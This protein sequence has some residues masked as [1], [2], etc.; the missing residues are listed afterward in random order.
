MGNNSLHI[1]PQN[2]LVDEDFTQVVLID[3]G[4]A[5]ELEQEATPASLPD[6][7]EGTLAYISPEQTGRTARNLDSRTDLYSLGVTFFEMLTGQ[8]PFVE[9]DA[10]AL[11]Y[12]H[13]AKTP[14]PLQSLMPNVPNVVAE[15]LAR[16]LEK[17]PEKR[18]QTAHGLGADLERCLRLLLAHDHIEAFA[19]GQQDYSPRLQIPQTLLSREQESLKLTA[20]FE[21][22]A[23]GAVEVLLLSGPS[24]IGKTALVHSVYRDIAKAGRGI[25]LS[26]KHDQ[27]GQSVP[28]AALAQAFSKLLSSLASSKRPMFE[29]WQQRLGQ[30]LGPLSRVIA[31]LVPQLEWLLGPLPAVPAVS[32]E[33]AYNRLKLSW[34]DFVRAVSDASPPLV[35]F[36]DD[37]Q[38]VD[39][40]SLELLKT[41][42]TDVGRKHLLV[43]AAY[44][45]NEVDGSHSLWKLIEAVEK[46]GVRTSR[47]T[48]GPLDESAVQMWLAAT[49]SAEPAR[50]KPLSIALF[51][52]TQGNPFFLGQLLIELHRQK[53]VRRNLSDGI[54]QWDQD[55]VEHAEVTANVVEL[56]RSKVVELPRPTQDLLGKAACA[57]HTFSI[58]ELAALSDLSTSQVV[59]A[60]RP[61]LLA[62]LVIPNEG[63]YRQAQ[64]LAKTEQTLILDAGYRFLHDRVQQ[65][66]YERIVQEER[67]RTHLQIGRQLYK[68]FEQQ[69]GSNQKLLE[70][71]RHLNLGVGAQENAAERLKLARLN[72]Q[73][74]KAAKANGSYQLQAALVEQSQALL[75]MDAWE[76]EPA[77]SIDLALERLE[78]D[79]ML[80]EFAEVHRRALELLTRPLPALP[81]LAVQELRLRT[82]MA[83]GQFGEGERLGLSALAEHGLFYPATNEACLAEALQGITICDAWLDANPEAFAAMAIDRS[84]EHLLCDAIQAAMLACAGYGSRPA[85][86]ILAI[87]RNTLCTI[88]KLAWTP[89]APFFVGALASA[90]AAFLGDYR[91][92][93]R[94]MKE[95]ARG[96][97]RLSSPTTAELCVYHGLYGV[98]ES[99]VEQTRAYCQK[100]LQFARASGSFA[101]TSTALYGELYFVELWGGRPLEQVA[102]MEAAQRELMARAGGA[103][104]RHFFA[105]AAA[106]AAFLRAPFESAFLTSAEWLHPSSRSFATLGHGMMAELGRIQ[107]A[108]LFL[109]FGEPQ[110]AR[111]RAEEAERFRASIYGR[112]PVTDIPLW[113]GLAAAKCCLPTLSQAERASLLSTLEHAIERFR[114]FSAACP[115]N[116]LHKL[117]LL[118][119]E[120]DR[121]CDRPIEAMEKYDAAI[122]LAHQ[123]RFLHIEGLAAQFCGEFHLSAGRERIAALYLH[124][125]CDAYRR[126]DAR[127]LVGFLNQKYSTLLRKNSF[128][129]F[130][131]ESPQTMTSTTSTT[132]DLSLDVNTTVRAAQALASELDSERIVAA[133]MRLVQENAGAQRAALL[134]CTQAQLFVSALLSDSQ[135][136]TG[137]AEPLSPIHPVA[138]SIVEYVLRSRTTLVLIDA[139]TDSQF[140]QDPHLRAE[141]IH[142]VLVIP[143]VHQGQL[144]GILYLEHQATNAFSQARVHLLGVLAAQSAIALETARLYADLQAANT[145][146]ERKVAERTAALDKA[147][148]ELWSEMDVAQKIQ[149]VL[150]P[151]EPQIA[152]YEIAAVMRPADQVGGDYYDVFRRGEQDWVLIGDVSGH[153]VPA[154]LCMMMIQAVLRAV[155]LSLER[156]ATPR[157]LLGLVNEAVADNLKQIGR[158]QYMTITALCIENGIIHYAGLHQELLVFRAASKQVERIETQGVWLGVIDGDISE[159][160]QDDVCA[161][162]PGDVLL[163]YTDGYP[164]AKHADEL[165]GMTYLTERFAQLAT[166]TP[167]CHALISELLAPLKQAEVRD[168]VTLIAL[169]RL[170]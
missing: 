125:A 162:E 17:A 151:S 39:P 99:P 161:L 78:A 76:Q 22:A 19:L 137:L 1:Q 142:S 28:Y 2:I 55:A 52:K 14:P 153:G 49:L 72:L 33:M 79:F 139:L 41:L 24:G 111:E 135:V 112:P 170:A 101:G 61:A 164:E 107:E 84:Q 145:G 96:A 117:R 65:A 115:E 5:S 165:L 30:A 54:W 98:Y 166:G 108:H 128:G 47:L 29:A 94:W 36:L 140:A 32:T 12:A 43:I 59:E 48:V 122:Q 15:L 62:G 88:E 56:M 89:V 95:G 4:I 67:A 152:G 70:L 156:A 158:G 130:S 146:L 20:A 129:K 23:K 114:Y 109:A 45:D 16:C 40:A 97:E 143:L 27:L 69:G 73:A 74:A 159:F 66:C 86:A 34:I 85:L 75:G 148:K 71:V 127:S 10:L 121:L 6:S 126:W 53:R 68:V 132:G 149:T 169:R 26:G 64:A 93:S 7:I 87:V 134:L 167:A 42:L 9:R 13:L 133:L 118:E 83:S 124:D 120:Q 92:D 100:A 103:L 110:R 90:R 37:V 113:R 102:A 155:A 154:G 35:L 44:R 50:V 3:F 25:L 63:S 116:F 104:G 141:G 160:L 46:S 77:L 18:Y 57:G 168:D 136:R 91:R 150:L 51:H 31:D 58:G 11:V 119:A 80:R 21:R 105:L 147:L 8:R 60:L 38:W 157:R 106:Y 144:S 81:R 131:A 138:A 163:L 123:E 82:Y